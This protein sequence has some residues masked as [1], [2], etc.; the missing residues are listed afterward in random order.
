MSVCVRELTVATGLICALSLLPQ[1]ALAGDGRV[2]VE[3]RGA[4]CRL[5]SFSQSARYPSIARENSQAG[6]KKQILVIVQFEGWKRSQI[7]VSAKRAKPNPS[8]RSSVPSSEFVRP[9][10]VTDQAYTQCW[11]G[12]FAPYVCTSGALV[13]R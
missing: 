7:K 11:T 2:E 13:C 12:V 8:M 6:L 10:V 5:I 3:N 4:N 1:A 9:D